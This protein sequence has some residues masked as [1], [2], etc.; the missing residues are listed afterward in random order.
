MIDPSAYVVAGFG[1]KGTNDTVSPMPDVSKGSVGFSDAE[2]K[3]VIAYLQD[4]GGLEVTVKIPAGTE[5]PAVEEESSGGESRPPFKTAEEAMVELACG[6][7]HK[8][9]GEE[10]E[11][12]PDL[13]QIGRIRDKASLRQSILDPNAEITEGFEPDA[14]P[15][16]YGEQL[17]ANE[18]EM[19]VDY[20]AAQK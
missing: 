7:C 1:K 17:F 4:L 3:A 9:A 8:I 13:T 19:V 12:G 20:L 14:M 16:D 15:A 5:K 6:A 10:G 18:L 11:L 2:I